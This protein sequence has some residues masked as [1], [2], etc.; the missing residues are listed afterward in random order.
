VNLVPLVTNWHARLLL[1]HAA[2]PFR[3]ELERDLSSLGY[4]VVTASPGLESLE[5]IARQRFS[6]AV[7]N[8]DTEG[9]AGAAMI[10]RLLETESSL[11]IVV[12]SCANDVESVTRCMEQGAMEYLLRPVTLPHLAR[13]IGRTLERRAARIAETDR[14]QLLNGEVARLTVELRRERRSSEQ[15]S[16]AALDSLVYMMEAQDR[17]LAGH[18]VRV[19]QLAASM[20]AVA[21]RTE[22]EVEKVRLAGRLHDIGMLCI[23]EGI[24]SK[25]GPLTGEEFD[26]V[27]QHV[28][29]GSEILA[30]LP[31]LE[32]VV[33]FV[34]SHHERWNGTGYPDGLV[35]E[36][37]AWG[38]AF[39][40]TAEVYDALTTSRPYH[41]KTSP[42][43]ALAHMRQLVGTVL[44]PDAFDALA[45]IVG[46]RQ[47]LVFIH[48]ERES[49]MGPL[50]NPVA[51]AELTAER[52]AG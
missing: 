25:Q 16:V 52:A 2:T 28:I 26:R 6:C 27:K 9:E 24:L 37:I 1:V 29:V 33:T 20:A 11:G 50:E 41:E 36:A 48:G 3:T 35:G 19:A 17:Y 47:A 5:V 51:M 30:R 46:G 15:Q 40:G 18:S 13:A 31:H 32:T 34:R 4:E 8:L 7:L 49:N 45:T 12:L 43:E 14:Q 42:D 38:A 39:I 23:G 10:P 44:S 21:G 22:E